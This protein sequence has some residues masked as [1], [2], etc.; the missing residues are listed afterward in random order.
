MKT[1]PVVIHSKEGIFTL[2]F[3][4]LK[5]VIYQKIIEKDILISNSHEIDKSMFT[6]HSYSS[7]VWCVFIFF[8]HLS[9]C[10]PTNV[11]TVAVYVVCVFL[12]R[13]KITLA[14][15]EDKKLLMDIVQSHHHPSTRST[16]E[17]T[18][19]PEGTLVRA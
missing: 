8:F 17:R 14:S 1:S 9:Q 11:R 3:K 19:P 15:T 6:I 13:K 2:H 4:F 5:Q 10:S 18:P 12:G 7:V 16:V